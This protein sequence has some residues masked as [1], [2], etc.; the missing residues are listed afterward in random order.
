[1]RE[2]VISVAWERG[3]SVVGGWRGIPSGVLDPWLRH[4]AI[5]NLHSL[6]S[7]IDGQSP[8]ARVHDMAMTMNRA[9]DVI[10]CLRSLDCS[11]P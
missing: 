6:A 4:E 11:A 1:L 9:C 10:E 7:A 5:R 3:A 2:K 8:P